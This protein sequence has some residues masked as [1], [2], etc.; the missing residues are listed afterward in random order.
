MM[1]LDFWLDQ[2]FFGDRTNGGPEPVVFAIVLCFVIGQIIGWVYLKTHRGVSYSQSFTASLVVLPIL[3]GQMMLLMRGSLSIAFGLLAVF[4]VVRFRNVL[5]D[6]RDTI[7]VLW[8]II[9]GMAVGTG[10]ASTAI[11]GALA[12]PLVMFYLNVTQF[13]ARGHYD[14]IVNLFCDTSTGAIPEALQGLLRRHCVEIDLA[15]IEQPEDNHLDLS[16]RLMLRDAQK[17]RELERDL[18]SL[19][20][21]RRVSVFRHQDE[22]E[23]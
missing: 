12:L 13:G 6:T 1:N 14:T 19:D 15:A 7:F 16:Y 21:V 3:V 2:I 20:F 18:K 4:A 11:I 17:R 5:K 22:S 8:A 9:E 10:Q 23:V